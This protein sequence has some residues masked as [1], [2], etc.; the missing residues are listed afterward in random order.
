MNLISFMYVL[1]FIVFLILIIIGLTQ[2]TK[3]SFKAGFIFFVIILLQKA[4]AN[5][6]PYFLNRI[7]VAPPFKMN[8]GLFLSLHQLMLFVIEV[9]AYGILVFGLYYRWNKEKTN[10]KS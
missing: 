9:C 10:F 8:I 5:V 2:C 6:S 4:Y 3:H 7:I 1:I